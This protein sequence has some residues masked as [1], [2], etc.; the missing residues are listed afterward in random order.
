MTYERIIVDE[1]AP[2]VRRI[3]LNNPDKRNPLGA[4]MRREIMHALRAHDVDDSVRVTIIRGAGK[5]FSAGYDLAGSPTDG[6]PPAYQSADGLGRHRSI[7]IVSPAV[8]SS[9]Q[10]ATLCMWPMMRVSVIPLS[11]LELLT[12]NGMHGSLD[13]SSEWNS[14]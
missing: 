11:V 12:C 4:T 1:P 8:R 3:T 6:E 13:R 7:P 9:R 5:C 14:C 2:M 10:D